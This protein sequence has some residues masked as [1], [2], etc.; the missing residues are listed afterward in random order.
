MKNYLI[1]QE[2]GFLTTRSFSPTAQR[3]N[4]QIHYASLPSPHSV[5]VGQASVQYPTQTELS[6]PDSQSSRLPFGALLK[7]IYTSPD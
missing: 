6:R 2:D 3:P 5:R 1:T 4:G 7:W